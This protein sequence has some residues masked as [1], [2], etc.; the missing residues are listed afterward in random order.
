MSHPSWACLAVLLATLAACASPPDHASV[1]SG[2][3]AAGDPDDC[4]VDARHA[5]HHRVLSSR[6]SIP[7]EAEVRF[8][9]D[10]NCGSDC[11]RKR[12]ARHHAESVRRQAAARVEERRLKD[13]S[14][15]RLDCI[16]DSGCVRR[17]VIAGVGR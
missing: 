10:D 11:A 1:K 5:E 9:L 16:L 12:A 7:S 6:S 15:K 4:F 2:G 14:A 17:G 3:M 13:L 8:F